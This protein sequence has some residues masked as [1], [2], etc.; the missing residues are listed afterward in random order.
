M[1]I[2][3]AVT[4]LAT[5][6]QQSHKA[7]AAPLTAVGVFQAP[8]QA[9]G[10]TETWTVPF[11]P[12]TTVPA[13]G[14]VTVG[15]P[16]SFT[17][18]GVIAGGVTF[19]VCATVPTVASV[20][21]ATN[22]TIIITT[23]TNATGTA[24]CVVTVAGIV[25]PPT[26]ATLTTVAGPNTA[27]AGFNVTTS[28]D[29]VTTNAT[30]PKV[31]SAISTAE[32][33]QIPADGA[34]NSLVTFA[35]TPAPPVG[36]S[37]VGCS[38]TLQTSTGSFAS[39]AFI[40]G[41][42][43]FTP[44]ADRLTAVAPCAAITGNI[45]ANLTAPTAV[46][47]ASVTLRVTPAISGSSV[48]V[49]T[50]T[51]TFTPGSVTVTPAA[52]SMGNAVDTEVVTITAVDSSGNAVPPGT[53]VRVTVSTGTFAACPAGGAAAPVCTTTIG[54]GTGAGA[55]QAKVT[56]T[57]A[58]VS[59]LMRITATVGAVSGAAT[60]QLTGPATLITLV[61]RRPDLAQAGSVL[62]FSPDPRP[63]VDTLTGVGSD[64]ALA[65]VK[66]ANGNPIAGAVVNY[67]VNP[68]DGGVSVEN[69]TVG[70]LCVSRITSVTVSFLGNSCQAVIANATAIPGARYTIT[71]STQNALTG[72][73]FSAS[74]VVTV[75]AAFNS[76]NSTIAIAAADT[77]VNTTSSITA[78]LR[79]LNGRL[80]GDGTAVTFIVT[81]GFIAEGGGAV[82]APTTANG[83]AT[84][85][86][87]APPTPCR[88]NVAAG[89]G[90][91]VA[92]RT[93]NVVNAVPAGPVEPGAIGAGGLLCFTY[94]G[95]TKAFADFTA[96]F[97]ASV[98]GINV[99][100]STGSFNSWFRALPSAATL[101]SVQTGD[102]V[103][104]AGV[105]LK[106]FA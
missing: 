33:L 101:T 34:S 61:S 13:G 51:L 82:F 48:L 43:T 7:N 23:A 42:L 96:Y 16:T 30:A 56:V 67:V 21:V 84:V 49:G 27:T 74:T 44:R 53:A 35:I 1:A 17:T 52:V 14:T 45:V 4:L 80:I 90:S 76:T 68:N 71:A 72:V 79:D 37:G 100:T 46:G 19:S 24:A 62:P 26:N 104:A 25:N 77:P 58:G 83:V 55:G 29:T 98:D 65:T 41:G 10:L 39:G 75:G 105:A 93:F 103:C 81:C 57:G 94:S 88:V 36:N 5:V 9:A 102:R 85:T 95:P 50:A 6:A 20:N 70:P 86:F 97:A 8:A 47:S 59:L 22:G 54:S 18:T 63:T 28:V 87:V 73:V 92:T 64:V 40:T 89:S 106:V 2:L 12:A 78:T 3:V 38:V 66:D 99:Q 31:W 91:K 69:E 11:T 32:P 15:F 60:V